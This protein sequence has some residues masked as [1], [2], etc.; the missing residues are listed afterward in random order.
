MPGVKIEVVKSVV[1]GSIVATFAAVA[2]AVGHV[3]YQFLIE[4]V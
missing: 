2:A 1:A 3:A 4:F